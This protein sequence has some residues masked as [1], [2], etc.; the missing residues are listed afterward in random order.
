M[1]N[2]T[3]ALLIISTALLMK[4][5]LNFC[6]P[7]IDT[8][9]VID[10]TNTEE[11]LLKVFKPDVFEKMTQSDKIYLG[12][13]GSLYDVTEGKKF[14]GPG[15]SYVFFAGKDAT[16]AF[17]T[18]DFVNDLNDNIEDLTDSQVA[19]LFNWKKTYDEGPY[20][21]VGYL[22]GAFYDKDG[23]KKQVLLDAEGKREVHKQK[24]QSNSKWS[25]RFPGCNSQWS[26]DSGETKV[27][28]STESGGV[29]RSWVGVPRLVFNSFHNT[30][31]CGCVNKAD[32]EHPSVKL[33]DGCKPTASSCS[34]RKK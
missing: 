3:G 31:V 23:Q 11:S 5:L 34:F 30:D 17:A 33:Y 27:W 28:C 2:F 15:G 4:L 6:F 25:E 8:P 18:G 1:N 10:T 9:P 20:I 12:F 13:L 24:E 19:D 21:F 29:K 16:R 32:L 26:G 22:E 14:Y 7:I